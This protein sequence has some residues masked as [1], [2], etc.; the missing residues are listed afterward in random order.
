MAIRPNLDAQSETPLYRQISSYLQE[1]IR[2]GELGPGER[3]PPTRELAGL[4]GLNRTTVSAAYDL[5]ESEGLIK[6]E[7]GRGSYVC[8]S[9]E[10]L[11]DRK[12]DQTKDRVN[13]SRSLTASP[14]TPAGTAASGVINFSSS[15]PSEAMFPLDEFRECCREVLDNA[16][17]RGLMQLG[18]P[19]GYEPLRRYLLARASEQRIARDTDDILI[20]NGCQQ[21]L[22][23]L[24]RA[25][26]R[27]G[28]KVALEEPV[29][30]GL[31]NLLLEA[32]ADLLGVPV[33][34]DG[35]DLPGLQRALDAGA[36]VVVLTPSF[37]NPTGA[38]IPPAH[39]ATI[40]N[41][42]R[43]AGAALIEND[44][45][46]DLAYSSGEAPARLKQLDGDVILMGSFSKIAFPG[47]RVGW[48]LAP[49][50]VIARA[51]ELKQLADL[52]TDHLSQAFLLRF[53]ESGRLAAHQAKVV[54]AG[55]EKLRAVEEACR[56]HLGGCK[57]RSPGGGM[58][59]WV[60]L[61]AGVD[62]V[63]LRGLAQ[64][65]G[66][67]Y[68]PGRYFSISQ[69]LDSGLRLSFAGLEPNEIRK[70]I[71]ILGALVHRTI[72]SRNSRAA[73]PALALV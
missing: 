3:L 31:K 36:K 35:I 38:S 66:I 10:S 67:D 11:P 14:S 19:G 71:E 54:T 12:N 18:S 45:Y 37:Q 44:I 28:D 22:D 24:R 42:I 63:A 57:W 8:G 68:L 33:N 51:T 55:K 25:L 61:P 72:E 32:G 21:A 65:A 53:A 39:R 5:L 23:L 2:K 9:P 27:S 34:A 16:N 48:I 73:Q 49:R 62:A 1:L 17:L 4:L 58:N 30:P 43:A 47:M 6:G 50:P 40:V 7:V 46:S 60:E 26:I 56:R 20:T 15:R 69:S 13:W 59:L 70:G 64:Q 29:Y 52:H 41:M